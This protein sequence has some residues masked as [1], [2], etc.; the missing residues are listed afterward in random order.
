M[1]FAA[2]VLLLAVLI[3]VSCNEN[4]TARKQKDNSKQSEIPGKVVFDDRRKNLKLYNADTIIRSASYF[5]SNSNTKDVFILKIEPGLVKHAKAELQIR[6]STGVIVYTQKFDAFFLVRR[7][8]E[9]DTVPKTGGQIAY[10]NYMASYWRKLTPAQFEE[11]F[12]RSVDSFFTNIY[13]LESNNIENLTAWEEDVSEKEFWKEISEDTTI[14]LMDIA[15]FDCEEG[16][17][18]IGYSRKRQE[19]VALLEHD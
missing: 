1:K 2:I 14:R 12:K 9:P 18:I 15:C 5:F 17:T 8:Y 7:I 10:E 11:Y 6:T 13:P 19:V 4:K 3:A 16:G